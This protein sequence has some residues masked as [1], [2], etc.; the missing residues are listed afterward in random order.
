MG[1]DLAHLDGVAV[2]ADQDNVQTREVA[3][4]DEV[5]PPLEVAFM[6]LAVDLAA[7]PFQVGLDRRSPLLD[8][9]AV[10]QA[11]EAPM[12]LPRAPFGARE[13]RDDRAAYY[14]QA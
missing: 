10:E 11:R 3:A 6:R 1:G 9:V 4:V 2:E 14:F 8:V 5:A 7:E 13:L 12:E